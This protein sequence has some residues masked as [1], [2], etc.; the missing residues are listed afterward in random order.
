MKLT[1]TLFASTL[2]AAT[3][4]APAFA[5]LGGDA[6]SVEADRVSLKGALR[7]TTQSGVAVH[8]IKSA[9][10][11]RVR[12]YL[13]ADGRV[14]AVSWQ[15]PAM[16][17]LRQ[18]LGSYSQQ[19]EQ[20]ARA[21]HYNHHHFSVHTADVVVESSAHLRAFYGRAWAPALLPQNF[22]AATIN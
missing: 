13:G 9:A 3:L 17:D 18:M 15:G 7:V 20:A 14:F 8:E 21:P 6:S 10:G 22:S 16:P 5:G 19:L 12:E 1:R 2:L 4:A 11:T